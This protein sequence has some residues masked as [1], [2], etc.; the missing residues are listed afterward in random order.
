MVIN[1]GHVFGDVKNWSNQL[2]VLLGAN[3]HSFSAF[4]V[5][6]V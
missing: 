3:K 5:Y 6:S 1:S 2:I 4:S